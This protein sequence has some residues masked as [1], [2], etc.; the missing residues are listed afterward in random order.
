MAIP[1][2]ELKRLFARSGNRCTFSDCRR[3]LIVEGGP[4]QEPVTLGDIAHIVA[5]SLGGPRGDSVLSLRDRN[6]YPNLILLC[7]RHHQL[8]DAQPQT[9]T[10]ER[11]R[12]I[13]EEHEKWVKATLGRGHDEDI[14][15]VTDVEDTVYST[16]LPVLQMPAFIYSAVSRYKT[17][18]EVRAQLGSLRRGEMAPFIVRE[19]KLFVFQNLRARGNPFTQVIAGKV[20]RHRIREWEDDP[21]GFRWLISLL[22]RSLNKLT[23]RRGLALDIDH[24]RYYFQM[25]EPGEPVQLTY[26]PLNARQATRGVVWQPTSKRTGAARNYWYHRAVSLRFMRIASGQWCLSIRPELR[27]T[28]DGFESLP[29]ES[30]GSRVTRKKS[31]L[32]NYDLLNEVHFWRDFLGSSSP[33]IVFPFGDKRQKIVVLTHLMEGSVSWPGIPP[34]HAKPFRN[35]YYVDD[36]FTWA[37]VEASDDEEEEEWI[38]VDEIGIEDDRSG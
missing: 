1:Q 19:N 18:E 36:L 2:K 30:I 27:V 16:L 38:V 32:F 33:R 20:E 34:E 25:T 11:L 31:R 29:S 37:E 10:P 21:D 3:L 9:Y 15:I 14:E 6:R 5:E 22:N 17:E 13:K 35:V 12:A 24:H 7:N 23:G 8:V 26:K 4:G 28:T